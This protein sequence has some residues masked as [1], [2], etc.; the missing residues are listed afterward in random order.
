MYRDSVITEW[1]LHISR[2]R[3]DYSIQEA[4]QLFIHMEKDSIRS[5]PQTVHTNPL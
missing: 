5:P 2:G 1:A 3:M 4:G